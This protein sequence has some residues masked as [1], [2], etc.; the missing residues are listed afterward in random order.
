MLLDWYMRFRGIDEW[1]IAEATVETTD[2]VAGVET[3]EGKSP[4]GNR[5]GFSYRDA[6]GVGHLGEVL[7][8]EGT[9]AFPLDPGDTL[10][11][12]F[13][14]ETGERYFVEGA[15]RDPG[16]LLPSL[17]LFFVLLVLVEMVPHL[18]HVW[19]THF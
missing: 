4:D 3:S 1:P 6:N 14:P 11:V 5:I 8:L 19:K 9:D 12:R 18:V 7:A 16:I 2:F 15:R 10:K 17:V 13:D